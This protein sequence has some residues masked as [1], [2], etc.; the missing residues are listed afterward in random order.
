MMTLWSVRLSSGWLYRYHDQLPSKDSL[1]C[2]IKYVLKTQAGK[3]ILRLTEEDYAKHHL[4]QLAKERGPVYDINIRVFKHMS[5]TITGWPGG[6]PDG[7][8]TGNNNC[9][10]VNKQS[11]VSF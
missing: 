5:H 2:Y 4:L 11:L 8:T 3:P 7:K 6:K 10:K 1:S 9:C